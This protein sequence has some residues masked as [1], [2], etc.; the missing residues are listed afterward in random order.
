M[1]TFDKEEKIKCEKVLF[2]YKNRLKRKRCARARLT[3]SLA[4]KARNEKF[5]KDPE[6]I[7]KWNNITSYRE[8]FAEWRDRE[9]VAEYKDTMQL[10]ETM[11]FRYDSGFTEQEKK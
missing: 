3:H 10:H 5:I 1:R 4:D 2:S 8:L 9:F 11:R 7:F 6:R